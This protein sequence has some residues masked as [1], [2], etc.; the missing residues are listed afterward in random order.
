MPTV[1]N[2]VKLESGSASVKGYNG[3]GSAVVDKL[4]INFTKVK[5]EIDEEADV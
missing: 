1:T 3:T 5:T 2:K 4:Q